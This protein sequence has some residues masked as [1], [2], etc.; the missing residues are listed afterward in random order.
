MVGIAGF[1]RVESA[2]VN[3]GI[4]NNKELE[5]FLIDSYRKLTE[6]N[7]LKLKVAKVTTGDKY[8]ALQWRDRLGA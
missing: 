6:N 3:T 4:N 2:T 8:G 5:S 1:S 7:L